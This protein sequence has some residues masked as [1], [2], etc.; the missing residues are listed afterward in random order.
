MTVARETAEAERDASIALAFDAESRGD[1]AAAARHFDKAER[2]DR[3][4]LSK[5]AEGA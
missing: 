1:D 2:K 5:M 3:E 4:L